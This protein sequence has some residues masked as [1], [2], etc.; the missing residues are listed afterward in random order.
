MMANYAEDIV[1]RIL[2]KSYEVVN[3]AEDDET[4]KAEIEYVRFLMSGIPKI[5]GVIQKIVNNF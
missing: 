4:N 3:E 5:Y 2:D 1:L